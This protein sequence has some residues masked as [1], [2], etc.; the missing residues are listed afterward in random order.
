MVIYTP[1][2]T[3]DPSGSPTV[4]TNDFE[5]VTVTLVGTGEVKS[6]KLKL[7]ALRGKFLT[8]APV[9]A[10]FDKIEIKIT[11]SASNVLDEIFEVD[12][13]IPIKNAAEG[14]AV[15]VELLG[16][17]HH[18]QKIDVAKQFF[19]SSAQTV[20][21]D[22]VDFYNDSNGSSS[23]EV[24]DHNTTTA[25]NN[26]LPRWTANTYE[27]GVSEIK[28]Y[29]ALMVVINGLGASVA[30]GGA[31]DF[32][33]LYFDSKVSDPT[34][35]QFRAFSS[36]GAPDHPDAGSEITITDS[37]A[38]NEAPMEGG[39]DAVT[40]TLVKAWGAKGVGT[41]PQSVES[42]NGE[43]EAFAL[44][45]QHISGLTYPAGA[46]VQLA[47]T[48]YQADSETSNT[49][50]TD[51][52]SKT[53][54]AIRGAANGYSEWTESK[55]DEW[56]SSGSDPSASF[57]GLGCWDSNMVIQDATSFMTWVHI[58][59][60]TD[61]FS[62]FLKYGAASGGNYRG[63]RCLVN[64]TG[65]NGFSSNDKFGKSFDNNIA[66]Y[67]GADW[68][69]LY[70]T[71]NSWSC[72]VRDEGKVY[73]KSGGTWGD[74]SGTAR[75]NHC[76]HIVNTITN[77]AGYNS[78][79]DDTTTFGASS[80]VEWR[81]TYTAFDAIPA[82]FFTSDGYYKI[83]AWAC[84]SLPFPENSHNS[85]TLGELYGNNGTKKEPATIDV[86]NMHLDRDGNVGF[87]A[88]NSKDHGTLEAIQFWAK[89]KWTDSIGTTL[90]GNF[91]MR[92]TLYDNQDNV[93]VQDFTIPFNDLWAQINLP[94]SNFSPYRAR[95]PLALGNIKPNLFTNDLE[96]LNVFQWKNIKL[97]GIQ[98]QEVY[99]DQGRYSPEGSRAIWGAFAGTA[100]IRLA[101][102]GFC[103]T[104]PLLAIT[105]KNTTRPIEP[106]A[107]QFPDVS[108]SVQLDQIVN[109]QLEIEQ[110]QHKEYTITTEGKIDINFGD[111]FFLNDS[112]LINDAD[113][114]T[115]DSGGSS[116][117]IRLVAKRIVYKITKPSSTG[118][119]N[120]LRTILG[121][122]RFV[123]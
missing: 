82:S 91:K 68:I 37:T 29:D 65:I 38:V 7:N 108:N 35:I 48:H 20:T 103:F 55:V 52:T 114:R 57:K 76:F 97:I 62:V 70:V 123:T 16:Q 19:F 43:L 99:D 49:P 92:C 3:H 98:W 80:A 61:D 84:F 107:M 15:E 36:G 115:A 40:G 5:E 22:I 96:I 27:F 54:A 71:S 66:I 105:A 42:F 45:P 111:T 11:D 2:I 63:L 113:T 110:F 89:F 6:A 12:R 21:E 67:D 101:L 81:W 94:F 31:A 25:G 121:I 26:E 51:W 32:F 90:Q 102:D 104:K 23:P 64:G 72:A 87:N 10:Q 77:V 9:L 44:H 120:F 118:G 119:G 41:L 34:K 58:K 1:V 100:D 95:I 93:V 75:A 122:K 13:I 24:E 30:A 60:T 74:D 47:G 28:A 46:R 106:P 85:N 117:T 39:I 79:S 78:T 109:S 112:T 50:P 73:I 8:T 83:G 116:N 86:N 18:L 53:F 88:T 17:E 33:E 4:I 59:S 56:K 14:Y 69:V